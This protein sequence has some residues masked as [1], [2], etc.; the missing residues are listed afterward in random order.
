[1][2]FLRVSLLEAYNPLYNHD[3]IQ[4]IIILKFHY[5]KHPVHIQIINKEQQNT[6]NYKC[7]LQQ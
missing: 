3:L 5:Y 6:N 2:T 7:K 4:F 1:M